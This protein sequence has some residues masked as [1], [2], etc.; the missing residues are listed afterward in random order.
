MGLTNTNIVIN[1]NMTNYGTVDFQNRLD[2]SVSATTTAGNINNG[3][4]DSTGTNITGTCKII[5]PLNSHGFLYLMVHCQEL[6]LLLHCV[7]IIPKHIQTI[8]YTKSNKHI[9]NY[10]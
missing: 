5:G 9:Y 6:Q 2:V 3:K 8:V 4:I 1:T 7:I 10:D